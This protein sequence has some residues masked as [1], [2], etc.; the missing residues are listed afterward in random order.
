MFVSGIVTLIQC[1]PVGP[2]GA[3]LPI[4]MGTSFGFVP[5]ATAIGT[6]YGIQGILGSLFSR[7][8]F[9]NVIRRICT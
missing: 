2:I 4:V 6:K 3:K 5:A 1:Y 8:D 7:C 9:S